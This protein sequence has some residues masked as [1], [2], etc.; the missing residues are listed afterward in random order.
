M[1]AKIRKVKKM[2]FEK[3]ADT[4]SLIFLRLATIYFIAILWIAINGDH[5]KF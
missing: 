4:A 5:F 2:K 3:I 1:K